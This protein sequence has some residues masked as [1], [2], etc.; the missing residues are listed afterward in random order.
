MDIDTQHKIFKHNALL[1]YSNGTEEE[2]QIDSLYR[3]KKPRNNT[4]LSNAHPDETSPTMQGFSAG[5]FRTSAAT[6]SS[7]GGIENFNK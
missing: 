4:L 1:R 3:K 7:R 2:S 5:N 6:N